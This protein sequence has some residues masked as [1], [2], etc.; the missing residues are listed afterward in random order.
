MVIPA[1]NSGGFATPSFGRVVAALSTARRSSVGGAA[2]C[3]PAWLSATA[4]RKPSDTTRAGAV[5]ANAGV[6]ILFA[7]VRLGLWRDGR[8]QLL[9]CVEDTLID[10]W[11]DVH[12]STALH[13]QKGRRGCSM[14]ALRMLS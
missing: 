14:G 12:C 4:G 3:V 6:A 9:S 5:A 7:W 10:W 11:I 13:V 8:R 2:A 1:P